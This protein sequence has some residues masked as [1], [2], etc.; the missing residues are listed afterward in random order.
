VGG[1]VVP[2]CTK[3]GRAT[4]ISKRGDAYDVATLAACAARLKSVSPAFASE[5]SYAISGAPAV[6]F[7]AIV[8]AIDALRVGPDGAP[9][10]TDVQFGVPR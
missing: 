10:F 7:A 9:L 6:P 2:G 1:G 3:P 4:S 5:R 8:E